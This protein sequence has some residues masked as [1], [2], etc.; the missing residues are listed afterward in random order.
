M[1][2]EERDCKQIKI[3]GKL[4]DFAEKLKEEERKMLLLQQQQLQNAFPTKNLSELRVLNL[5]V[6]VRYPS[7]ISAKRV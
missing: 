2:G 3:Y 4:G 6:W 5:E 7:N 1:Q